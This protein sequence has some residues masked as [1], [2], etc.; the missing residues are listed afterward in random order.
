MFCQVIR[1][2]ADNAME[3]DVVTRYGGAGGKRTGDASVFSEHI[4]DSISIPSNAR[5]Q[6]LDLKD[7]NASSKRVILLNHAAPRG[8]LIRFT[9]K[10]TNIAY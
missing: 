7:P 6:D 3:P 8:L 1:A 4:P 5:K 2:V 9:T 10:G